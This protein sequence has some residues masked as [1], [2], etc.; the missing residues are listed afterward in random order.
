MKMHKRLSAITLAGA[1]IFATGINAFAAEDGQNTAADAN[2]A[3]LKKAVS[4]INHDGYAFEPTITYS[5]T[6]ANGTASGTVTDED[7]L[8]VSYKGGDVD[9]LAGGEEVTKT[10]VFD[11]AAAVSGET[12]S[13]DLTWT[14]APDAFPSAGVYR[15]TITEETSVDPAQ[16]GIARSADYD[17]EKFLDVYVQNG[18]DGLEIYGLIVVDDEAEGVDGGSEKS[19][20]WITGDDLEVYETYNMTVTKQITGAGADM[21]AEF[22]FAVMLEGEMGH[23]NIATEGSGDSISEFTLDENGSATVTGTLGDKENIVIKGLPTTVRFSISE[24][25][26]TRE[27]YQATASAENMEGGTFADG[28]ALDGNGTTLEVMTDGEIAKAS[29]AIDITVIN[30]LAAIS[31]TGV[32][33]RY[34]PY[35]LILAAGIVIFLV[36]RSRREKE[37]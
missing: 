24:T 35:L 17:T 20:G 37:D 18:D 13:R 9:Y 7:G 11:S 22:P 36:S 33:L 19:E 21:T 32:V 10:A 26:Q 28:T 15:Y 31:P 27:T 3:V 34:A 6:L 30:D 12:S 1:M 8:T 23:A 25:N 2:T 29:A 14:F 16:I 4:V 5:Y